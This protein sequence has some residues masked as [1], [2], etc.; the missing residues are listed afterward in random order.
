MIKIIIVLLL[1]YLTFSTYNVTRARNLALICADAFATE[2]EINS[3]TCKYCPQ[4]KLINVRVTL[5]RLKPSIILFLTFSVSPDTPPT[6]MLSSSP[7]E[8]PSVFKTG[9]L[10]S[11]QTK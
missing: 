11:M 4:Y 7:L 3:W 6:I 8:V 2:A 5:L 1:S 9:L 10:I